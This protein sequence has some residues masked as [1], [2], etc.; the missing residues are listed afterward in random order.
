MGAC[1]RCFDRAENWY[2]VHTHCLRLHPFAGNKTYEHEEFD[3]KAEIYCA[4]VDLAFSF[5]NRLCR[6]WLVKLRLKTSF[7]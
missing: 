3:T 2:I 1:C 6:A 7:G 5:P 4:Y